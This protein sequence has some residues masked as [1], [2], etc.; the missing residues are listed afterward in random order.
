M[1]VSFECCMLSGLYNGPI[2]R[3]E[4]SYWLWCVTVWSRKHKNEA[5]QARGGGTWNNDRSS[6]RKM[7]LH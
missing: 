1:S 5:A 6:P 4:E 7:P 2:P 3:A